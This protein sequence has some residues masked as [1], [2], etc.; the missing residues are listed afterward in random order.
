V[1]KGFDGDGAGSKG[2][3]TRE[4]PLPSAAERSQQQERA[5]DA[6]LSRKGRSGRPGRDKFDVEESASDPLAARR[7]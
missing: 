6:M 5:A 2:K 7:G 4:D 3:L 1:L